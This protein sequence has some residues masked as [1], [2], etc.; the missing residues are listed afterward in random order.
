MFR[1][2]GRFSWVKQKVNFVEGILASSSFAAMAVVDV[3][4][5]ATVEMVVVVAGVVGGGWS[6]FW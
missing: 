3:V 6:G 5:I 1:D 2:G 4:Q